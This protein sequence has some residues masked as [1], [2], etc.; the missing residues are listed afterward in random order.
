[1]WLG[2]A[3]ARPYQSN[4]LPGVWRFW[5]DF[6]AGD[7]GNDGIHELDVA[8][9][10]LGVAGLPSVVTAAGSKFFFDDDQQFPDTQTCVYEWPGDGRVGT[11]RQLVYEQRDWSPY[12]QEGHENGVAFYGTT[13]YMIV[14]KGS[15]EVFG[16]KNVPGEKMTGGRPDLAAHHQNFLDCIR[17]GRRPTADVEDGHLSAALA[18]LG[19]IACRVGRVLRLDPAGE[20]IVGDDAAN[21]M[22][23]RTYRDGHWAVPKGV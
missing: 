8:R 20:R 15:F 1:L 4:L 9:W 11:K 2:P 18:H 12:V 22:L 19:N 10:G 7:I 23:R 16:R 17:T 3:P 14:G 21:G 13:G 5:Y 6:G